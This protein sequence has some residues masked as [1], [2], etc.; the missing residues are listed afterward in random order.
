MSPL[1]CQATLREQDGLMFATTCLNAAFRPTTYESS[2]NSAAYTRQRTRLASPTAGECLIKKCPGLCTIKPP[3]PNWRNHGRIEVTEIDTHPFHGPIRW[4]P[5]HE[6]TA[7]GTA[8]ESN[9]FVSPHVTSQ[10]GLSGMYLH[11]AWIVIAHEAAIAAANRAIAARE[12]TWLCRHLD[13]H[14]TAVARTCEH[15]SVLL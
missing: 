8:N 15:D 13:L 1:I 9:T 5:V 12:A 10:I 7:M 11:L 4:F 3:H 6:A 14:R 2:A